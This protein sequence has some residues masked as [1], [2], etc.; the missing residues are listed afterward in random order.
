M[1]V[2]V[3]IKE[4]P[5]TSA[6][7]QLNQGRVS[8]TDTSGKPNII[9]PWDEYAIEE[10]IR[11]KERAHADSVVAIT[12]GGETPKETLKIALA[13]GCD[14]AIILSDPSF[15][16]RLTG[17][18]TARVLAAA[19][20]KTGAQ[21]AFFG[22]Q[23][24]DGDTGMTPV[25][26]ARA[27][28]WSA[29]TAVSSIRELSADSITVDRLLEGGVQTV[30]A[31]LPVVI[32]VVKEINEPRFPSF[33]GIRKAGK[34]TIPTWSSADLGVTLTAQDGVDWSNITY[35]PARIQQTEWITG[36][37]PQAIAQALVEKLFAEKVI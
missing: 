7:F 35:P 18:D 21:I 14:E 33:I 12:L 5:S 3:C 4:T 8:W 30:R 13:M 25:M 20:A 22:K 29:L 1:K 15:L 27:L 24:I 10:A 2:A 34:A 6:D 19:I 16:P 23:A 31:K 11:L 28:Q 37:S 36:D 9:N 26:T 32:S 17:N